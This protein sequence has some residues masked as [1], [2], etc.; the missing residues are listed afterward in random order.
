MWSCGSTAVISADRS[1]TNPAHLVKR[2]RS[3]HQQAP[4]PALTL[5]RLM[6]NSG[7]LLT[8]RPP[9]LSLRKVFDVSQSTAR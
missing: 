8:S 5:P 9:E 2:C 4:L 6:N 1:A 7:G 3:M